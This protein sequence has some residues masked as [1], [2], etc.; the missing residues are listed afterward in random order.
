MPGAA[1]CAD[2]SAAKLS[3]IGAK[4]AAEASNPMLSRFENGKLRAG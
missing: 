4:A 3:E 2:G 1:R